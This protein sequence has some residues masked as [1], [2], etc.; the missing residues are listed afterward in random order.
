MRIWGAEYQEQNALLIKPDK[1][2]IFKELCKRE[3]VPFS[4]I[5]QSTG[6]GYIV[7]HDENNGSTPV[8]L[9]L[10]KILGDMPQK[11]F[12]LERVQPKLEPLKLPE[13]ITV[14][15]ALDR[16][17][18]L[19]SVGSKRFLTNKVDRSVTG[20]IARQ[21]CAGPL[22]L[23]VSDV[24]VIAQSHFGLTGA[25]ISIGEQPIKTLINPSAT[26]RLSV[27]EALTNIVWAKISK[28]EDIKC[29]GNW[30]WAAKLQGEG[31]RLYDAAVAVRDIMLELGIAID[32]G[33]DSLSMAA[34][35]KNSQQ[36]AVSSQIEG[37]CPRFTD[38]AK[39]SRR[40][41]TVPD[42]KIV[43]A[44]GSLVIS[45]YATCPDI[46]KVITPDIRQPGKSKLF[47]Y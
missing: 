30:M 39:R 18:R 11:T 20:L 26:A 23:T 5:G 35:V 41:G 7:L 40:I 28:L 32:G 29:S 8:N 42:Y 46:T 44:P 2:D 34:V 15:D 16:V 27:G 19:V 17:L 10:E 37:D 25:A 1:A 22:H 31:A 3:K 38:G 45:A 47:I 21:Q 14:R 13:D 36:S 24:A 9:D 4:F 6:D 43:K 33:K 12:K